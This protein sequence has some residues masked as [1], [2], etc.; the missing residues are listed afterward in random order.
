MHP[1]RVGEVRRPAAGVLCDEPHLARMLRRQV[2]C[3]T[4]GSTNVSVRDVVDELGH[5]VRVALGLPQAEPLLLAVG[6]SQIGALLDLREGSVS[7]LASRV[8]TR[9][10]GTWNDDEA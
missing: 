4:T 3:L 10:G 7:S 6:D 2:G 9:L 5:T 1:G 8:L